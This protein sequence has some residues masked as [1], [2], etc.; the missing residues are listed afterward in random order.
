MKNIA[1][2]HHESVD[3]TG[4]PNALKGDQIALEAKI[5]AVS[6]VFDALTSE[7]PYK[8]AWSNQHAFTMMKLMAIDRLDNDCVTAL[9]NCEEDLER[10]QKDFAEPST[11]Q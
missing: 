7:R 2:Q 1:E 4:Y 11:L 8:M 5:V 3:G 9:I 6:D 10:I